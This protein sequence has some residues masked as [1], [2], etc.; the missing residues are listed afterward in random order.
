MSDGYPHEDVDGFDPLDY[1]SD[2]DCNDDEFANELYGVDNAINVHDN[3]DDADDPDFDRSLV[4]IND[5]N[6]ND[7]DDVGNDEYTY[8]DDDQYTHYDINNCSQMQHG[9]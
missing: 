3:V 8:D 1:N 9:D 5:T 4:S 7:S 6:V 2:V